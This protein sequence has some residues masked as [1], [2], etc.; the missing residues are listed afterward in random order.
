MVTSSQTPA[1]APA[2]HGWPVLLGFAAGAVA[3]IALAFLYLEVARPLL[4]VRVGGIDG[5]QALWYGLCTPAGAVAGAVAGFRWQTARR[6]AP[7]AVGGPPAP[8]SPP[9]DLSALPR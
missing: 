3:G 8:A 5:E 7:P 9:L 6:A 2:R 4:G 1:G